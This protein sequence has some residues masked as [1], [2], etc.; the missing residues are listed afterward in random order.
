MLCLPLEK[1]HFIKPQC[2][3]SLNVFNVKVMKQRF[4][5]SQRDI[6]SYCV[7]ACVCLCVRMSACV[8]AC[9]YVCRCVTV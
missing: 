5:I 3:H 8:H 7:G 4:V 1:K 2:D 9:V 6:E